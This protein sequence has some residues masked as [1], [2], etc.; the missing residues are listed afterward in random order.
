LHQ[1]YFDFLTTQASFKSEYARNKTE[2]KNS[3]YLKSSPFKIDLDQ[4]LQKKIKIYNI[5][6]SVSSNI[7]S[8][9][10]ENIENNIKKLYRRKISHNIKEHFRSLIQPNY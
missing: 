9:L 10:V 6:K 4:N 1:F 8:F 5:I 3:Y 7:L 2:L